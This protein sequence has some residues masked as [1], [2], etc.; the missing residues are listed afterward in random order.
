MRQILNSVSAIGGHKQPAPRKKKNVDKCVESGVGRATRNEERSPT[1]SCVVLIDNY[2]LARE[3]MMRSLAASLENTV[4]AFS[5][6]ADWQGAELHQVDLLLY[7][8]RRS[9]DDSSEQELLKMLCDSSVPVIL[10]SDSEE[11]RQIVKALEFGVRGYISTNLTLDV[12]V[13]AARLV[14]A[15]GMFVPADS[16]IASRMLAEDEEAG[17]ASRKDLF[18]PRQALVVKALCNG[19]PNKIIAYELNMC[20]STVKVHVRNIMKK[21]RAKNRTEVAIIAS[22]LANDQPEIWTHSA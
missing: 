7:R 9:F 5:D 6:V 13:Q 20:E 16:L 19:K 18:T 14:M 1:S 4:L 22:K 17:A 21:L 12:A 3:C 2:T 11:P 8:L 10:L 15:G